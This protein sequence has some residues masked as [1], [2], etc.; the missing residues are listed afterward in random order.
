MPP[1]QRD[2]SPDTTGLSANTAVES[3]KN[4]VATQFQKVNQRQ[5]S[6][7]HYVIPIK[8][9]LGH[10]FTLARQ[11]TID[12]QDEATFLNLFLHK[13][14]QK[15]CVCGHRLTTFPRAVKLPSIQ[16]QKRNL[17]HIATIAIETLYE[18]PRLCQ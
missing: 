9:R 4:H 17:G 1:W 18:K 10:N 8:H 13:K 6:N 11:R 7:Q 15:H 2:V 14:L 16:V 5:Q 12:R 3:F